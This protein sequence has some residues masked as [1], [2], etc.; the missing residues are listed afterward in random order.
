MS[1]LKKKQPEK[2]NEPVDEPIKESPTNLL[3]ERVLGLREELVDF[4][5]TTIKKITKIEH[6]LN[7]LDEDYFELKEKINLLKL[8]EKEPKT[9]GTQQKQIVF[10]EQRITT[11]EKYLKEFMV[12]G[13]ITIQNHEK[14][15]D[16]ERNFEKFKSKE[17]KEIILDNPADEKEK[18]RFKKLEKE[19]DSLKND[20]V[21]LIENK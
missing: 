5:N 3:N 8:K 2:K 20:K 14:M 18:D 21:F 16:L 11:I 17:P 1:L 4:K 9:D 10:L 15:T 12:F 6:L 7:I 13:K 19:I